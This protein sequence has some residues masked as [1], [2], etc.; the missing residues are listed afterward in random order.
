MTA[1]EKHAIERYLF[2]ASYCHVR[3]YKLTTNMVEENDCYFYTMLV[4]T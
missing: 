4:N 3:F 1:H 2:P